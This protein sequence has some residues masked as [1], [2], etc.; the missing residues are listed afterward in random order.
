MIVWQLALQILSNT[1]RHNTDSVALQILSNT[2]HYNPDGV[3]ALQVSN[4]VLLSTPIML[5]VHC[6]SFHMCAIQI[7]SKMA[8]IAD[9]YN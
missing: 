8:L 5:I 9:I 3:V 6:T 4:C 1:L 2:I 7:L